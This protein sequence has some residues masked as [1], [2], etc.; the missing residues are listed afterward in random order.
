VARVKYTPEELFQTAEYQ[1]KS[2][3]D[4]VQKFQELGFIKPFEDTGQ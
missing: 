4:K 3:R 1:I 2:S